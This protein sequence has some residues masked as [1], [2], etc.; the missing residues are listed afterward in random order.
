MRLLSDIALRVPAGHLAELLQDMRYGLRMS[1]HSPGFTAVALISLSLGICVGTG[2][3]SE[4]TKSTE[5]KVDYQDAPLHEIEGKAL[6]RQSFIVPA[7]ATTGKAFL[8][9][10]ATV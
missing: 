5:V 4:L 3:F 7:T 8:T 2:A 10:T 1:A 6:Y 9:G